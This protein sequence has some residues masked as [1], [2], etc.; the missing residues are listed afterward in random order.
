M[1]LMHSIKFSRKFNIKIDINKL[2]QI[3]NLEFS[4]NI[5]LMSTNQIPFK[6]QIWHNEFCFPSQITEFDF[7]I[8]YIFNSENK[9]G[10]RYEK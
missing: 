6:S 9:Q 1:V 8:I 2:K 3:L 4:P 5:C 10:Y 7:F